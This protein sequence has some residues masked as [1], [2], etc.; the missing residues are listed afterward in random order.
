[1]PKMY[2]TAL[3]RVV[4]F[5][6]MQLKNELVPAVGNMRVNARGDELGENN[7]VIRNNNERVADYYTVQNSSQ[8][9]A[10]P[11][12]TIEES[13]PNIVDHPTTESIPVD[14]PK[15]KEKNDV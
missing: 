7:S 9:F 4:D 10:V 15:R 11:S 5:E 1:M 8:E 3:G 12:V 13:L 14:K 6:A 2:R